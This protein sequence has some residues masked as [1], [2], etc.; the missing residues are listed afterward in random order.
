MRI[1]SAGLALTLI[2]GS[3]LVLPNAS[4]QEITL[5]SDKAIYIPGDLLLVLGTVAPYDNIVVTVLNPNAAL[6]GTSQ[7]QS[8]AQGNYNMNVLRFPSSSSTAFPFG[9]YTVR[10]TAAEAGTTAAIIVAF[11]P[12]I[13]VATDKEV[14]TPDDLLIVSGE[15]LPDD[16]VVI[17]VLNPVG[18]L[19][20]CKN[21]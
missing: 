17:T 11:K 15:T 1:L 7:Q 19:V 8:D 16:E 4:A 5:R 18:N 6:V 13:S 2:L 14:Y 12:G 3:V 21:H 10:A 20:A 9:I